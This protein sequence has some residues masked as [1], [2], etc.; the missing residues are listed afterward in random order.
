MRYKVVN[1]VVVRVP[2]PH[3]VASEV[4]TFGRDCDFCYRPGEEPMRHWF[5]KCI[6]AMRARLK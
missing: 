1:G 4:V 2:V 3:I 6:T 5:S